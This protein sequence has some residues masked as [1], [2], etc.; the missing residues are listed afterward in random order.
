ME[1]GKNFVVENF[2]GEHLVGDEF[3][4]EMG[5]ETAEL[6]MVDRFVGGEFGR[7]EVIG[8][9]AGVVAGFG[10]AV[11]ELVFDERDVRVEL[12]GF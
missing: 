5:E 6:V 3:F 8:E 11:A 9:G 2:V 1:G 10:E 7:G 4:A 12:V